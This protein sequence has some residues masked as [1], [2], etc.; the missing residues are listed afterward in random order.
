MIILDTKLC[1]L[2]HGGRLVFIESE[3]GVYVGQLQTKS[4][5]T[6]D[7]SS[8]KQVC[9]FAVSPDFKTIGITLEDSKHTLIYYDLNNLISD[10]THVTQMTIH[11]FIGYW[12]RFLSYSNTDTR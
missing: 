4:R 3:K 1:I 9:Y 5:V 6:Y 12:T 10:S 11:L 8:W 2:T 7:Y